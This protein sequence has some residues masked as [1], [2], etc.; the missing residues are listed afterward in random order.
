MLDKTITLIEND[1]LYFPVFAI[2][3]TKGGNRTKRVAPEL[4]GSLWIAD[5]NM[6]LPN[7]L[8]KE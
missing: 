7:I 6:T 2:D 4:R 3:R 8:K 1:S 5:R